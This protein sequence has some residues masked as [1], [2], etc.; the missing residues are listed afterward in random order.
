MRIIV[1]AVALGAA[2]SARAEEGVPSVQPA[3]PPWL[4]QPAMVGPTRGRLE[5]VAGRGVS[6]GLAQVSAEVALG[7]GWSI[8]G[9]AQ[10]TEAGSRPRGGVAWQ[11][12]APVGDRTG[13]RLSLA[14]R[15]EGLVEPEGE[16]EAAVAFSRRLGVG[17]GA[18]AVTYGQDPEGRERDA[19]VAVALGRPIAGRFA[20]GAVVQGRRAL[21]TRLEDE[22]R[23]DAL[24]T[25]V[26]AVRVDAARLELALGGEL[27]ARRTD[28]VAGARV[29]A[30]VGYD[31]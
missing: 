22:R 1:V 9:G 16:V 12:R 24:A 2:G 5:I 3:R 21:G 11:A 27:L 18:L 15:P 14:Y 31:W 6:G 26:G 17:A 25:G 30:G 8:S 20:V 4:P 29:V 10:V 28:R 13:V 7:R 23:W 19:E